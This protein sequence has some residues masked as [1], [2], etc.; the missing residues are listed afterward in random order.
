MWMELG[1]TYGRIGG[2]TA[3]PKRIETPQEDYQSQLTWTLGESEPK[4]RHTRARLNT[5]TPD[6]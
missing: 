4:N 6:M 2:R 5:P 1:D 3:A